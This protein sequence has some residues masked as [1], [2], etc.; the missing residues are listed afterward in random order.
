MY[1]YNVWVEEARLREFKLC[2]MRQRMREELR[3]FG[4]DGHANLAVN[5]MREAF[6]N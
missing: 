4:T 5:A 1:A 3:P 6:S 2:K